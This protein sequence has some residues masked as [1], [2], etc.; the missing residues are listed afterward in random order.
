MAKESYLKTNEKTAEKFTRAIY[1]AQQWV[2]SHPAKD[3]AKTIQKEFADTDPAII[4]TSIERYKNKSHSLQTQFCKRMNGNSFNPL[5]MKPESYRNTFR[6]AN[7]STQ[8][9]PKSHLRTIGGT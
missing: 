5:W 4:E 9:S 3:I 6:T 2:E 8:K 1:R 7:S